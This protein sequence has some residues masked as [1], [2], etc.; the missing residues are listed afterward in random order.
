MNLNNVKPIFFA[1]IYA[2]ALPVTA[3]QKVPA[4][5]V[6]SIGSDVV[7]VEENARSEN[8]I[9]M[10][11]DAKIRAIIKQLSPELDPDY[12]G[13]AIVPG[14]Q[15]VIIKGQV[16]FV[17]DDGNYLVQG[18]MDIRRKRDIAQLGALPGLRL[19]ALK[20]IPESERIVFAPDGLR[21]HTVTVF[22]DIECVFCRKFHQDI[23]EYNK[24]GIVVEYVAYPRAGMGTP[25]SIKTES[26]W[27]STDR[28]KALTDAKN[29][30]AIPTL[31]CDSPVAKHWQIGQRIG[32]Q[33]TPMILNADGIALPGYMPPQQLLEA[34][35]GLAAQREI[36]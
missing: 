30:V 28:R 22:T 15:E 5:S 36:D 32:L 31:E 7:Q 6:V 19:L 27:C 33:G 34:L 20:D 9:D 4:E 12:I 14:Y 18:L 25:D 35:N 17:T 23:S 8:P 16:I 2:F 24:L 26:V 21:K 13:P 1:L 11:M 3:Q 29:E 10:A